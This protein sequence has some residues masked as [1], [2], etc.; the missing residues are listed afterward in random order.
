MKSTYEYED[1]HL[2]AQLQKAIAYLGTSYVLHKEY[3]SSLHTQHA[4]LGKLGDKK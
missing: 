3:K 4:V 1:Q 2:N